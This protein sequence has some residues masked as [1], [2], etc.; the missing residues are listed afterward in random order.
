[1]IKIV[2]KLSLQDFIKLNLHLLYRRGVT[3]YVTLIGILI[4]LSILYF[5]NSMREFPWVQLALGIF[6][7]IGLPIQAYFTSRNNYEKDPSIG[8]EVQY[9]IDW[10][11]IRKKSSTQSSKL[12]W[13]KVYRVT[14]NKD[15]ILIWQDPLI[16]H[17]IHK[18]DFKSE[19]LSKFREIVK[20]Q[21][22]VKNKLK[23]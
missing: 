13:E 19:D 8:E 14:E 16:S 1:M 15:W 6:C 4:L 18:R 20:G 5:F 23:S 21:E 17:P 12:M 7:T 2:T 9:E 11:S 10:K 3:K 22:N